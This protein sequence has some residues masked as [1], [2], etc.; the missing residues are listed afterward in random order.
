[1]VMA[2]MEGAAMA[3]SSFVVHSGCFIEKTSSMKIWFIT[4]TAYVSG[5]VKDG[6]RIAGFADIHT[7]NVI[8]LTVAEAENL[9][10]YME[11]KIEEI[12]SEQIQVP[13]KKDWYH[14]LQSDLPDIV[15]YQQRSPLTHHA[16]KGRE[17]CMEISLHRAVFSL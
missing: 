6:S 17:L 7:R 12:T 14:L 5:N 15:D 4:G 2:T 13:E 10:G 16:R 9:G 11:G 8:A 1:M 3:R